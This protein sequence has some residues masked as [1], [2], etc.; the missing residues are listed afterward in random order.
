MQKTP[1]LLSSA[2]IGV[3]HEHQPISAK[4]IVFALIAVFFVLV[5]AIDMTTRLFASELSFSKKMERESVIYSGVST[6]TAESERVAI[7]PF[8]P[9]QIVIPALSVDAVVEAVA[10][11]SRGEM[12]APAHFYTTS[13]YKLGSRPGEA[14]TTVIAGHFNS[15]IL[16]SGVFEHLNDLTLGDK[17]TV[18]GEGREATYVVREV[19]IYDADNAPTERIFSTEGD[20]KLIL[21]TCD[22]AWDAGT[23]R[24][25]KRLVVVALPL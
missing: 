2:K 6:P 12:Q 13:W 19:Y 22:G 11:N 21:V 9:K 25:D 1:L 20:S 17:I 24:Y 4:T 7:V 18:K 14:G 15:P 23:K 16:G 5:G 3:L 8:T 10:L